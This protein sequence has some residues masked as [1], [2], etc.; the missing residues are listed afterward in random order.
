V[1][2]LKGSETSNLRKRNSHNKRVLEKRILTD[3][4]R[5]RPRRWGQTSGTT[6]GKGNQM[7]GK[8]EENRK[9]Q[10]TAPGGIKGEHKGAA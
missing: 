6:D 3:G 8:K 9:Q 2:E 10:A 1:R 7:N 4:K 5:T